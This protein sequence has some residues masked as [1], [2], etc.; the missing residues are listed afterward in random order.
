MNQNSNKSEGIEKTEEQSLKEQRIRDISL[1]YYLQPEIKKVLFEF[2]QN[3]ECIPKYYEGFGKRPDI[4]QYENDIIEQVKKGATS[5]HCS[6]E[7]WS[8]PLELTTE[9]TKNELNKLRIG[10]DLLLDIDSKYLEYSKIYA[11]LLIDSLKFHGVENFGIKFSGSRGFHIIIPWKAFPEEVYGQK[12]KDMF[13][14]WPRIISEYLSE[15]IKPK[16]AEKIFGQLSLNE[17]AEKTGQKEQDLIID[18]CISCNKKAIKKFLITWNCK[19]CRNIE[20]TRYENKRIPKCPNDDCRK[21]LTEK[22]RKEIL[23]CEYCNFNSNDNPEMFNLHEKTEAFIVADLI[24]VS[25]RHLIRMPYSLHEKTSLSSIVI[26]KNKIENFQIIDAKP[27]KTKIKSFYPNA[28]ENEA[29]EL[30]LQSLDWHEQKQRE[31]LVIKELKGSLPIQFQQKTDFKKITI[32]NPSEYI[33]PPQIK[34]LLDGI[35]QDGR[36]RALMILISFFKSL[37]VPDNEIEKRIFEW[38]ELNYLP[39]KKGYILSQLNW[40]KRN[41]NRLPPN[42]DNSIYRDLM[43]DKPDKLALQTKNP[44]SYAVKKYFMNRK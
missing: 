37:G 28:K 4:F 21:P 13:P 7:L 39:L 23:L 25:P 12:T 26:D 19:N 41:P 29:K 33:F 16:L 8:E 31:E 40:Y 5:F 36:K 24:L 42:F 6:E 17:L 20:V 3:R 1:I 44:V 9:L 43:V 11:K 38:N 15:L 32:P 2:S 35:K 14:E 30:L 18:E 34:L 27:F 10:W 22:S